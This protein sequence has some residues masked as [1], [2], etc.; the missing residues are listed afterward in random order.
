MST[1][2][3]AAVEVR[4][5]SKNYGS[6]VALKDVDLRIN[7]GEY[8]ALLGPSGGGKTTLLRTIGG[9]HKP[10]AGQVLLHGRDVSAL[11]PDKRPTS[12]V[13]QSY[14]LFPH[15]TVTQ[16]VGYGL[17]LTKLPRNVIREKTEA[18]LEMVD[19][20]GYGA[21]K[22]HELSGGQQQRVQLARSL[23]LDRDI[24]LLDEPLAA[25]DAQLRKE[26]CLELKHLQRKVGI[27][28]IHVTHNQEEAMTV[29]D[30]IALIANGELVEQG[31]A[32]EV[33]ETPRR[34]F[35]AGFVG[36]N[37]ILD[38]EITKIARNGVHVETGAG[39][40]LAQPG[41]NPVAVGAF[42]SVSVRSE[43]VRLA[44]NDQD[45]GPGLRGTYRET[46]YL[47]LTTSHRVLLSDGTEMVARAVSDPSATAPPAPGAPIKLVW[48]DGA[49]RLLTN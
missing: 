39:E 14:A 42:V 37:N 17:S 23:V 6:V 46:V 28:F 2:S 9:F 7:A 32:R 27:T 1:Q 24:L 5:L 40:V 8:F 16:N 48:P 26:M 44:K 47:G 21:R 11:P 30:R 35:T 20:T 22:P 49:A 36:E 15:M 41:A 31:T 29:A 33:Y 13:F 3:P 25:L 43:L 45:N 4:G 34:R 12:M 10:T 19:L 38:G 18:M